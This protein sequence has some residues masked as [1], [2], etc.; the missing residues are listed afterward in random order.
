MPA[1]CPLCGAEVVKPEGEA[2]HR[3]PN[4]AC[5]SRGLET[6]IN[7]VGAAADIDGVGEQFVRRLWE[8][9]LAAL[10]AR[11]LPADDRAAA[12]ARGLRRGLGAERDRGDRAIANDDPV[13][14]RPLRPQH[15][16]R[17]LGDRPAARP[18]LRRRRPRCSPPARSSWSNARGSAPNAPRRSPSGSP[19]RTTAAW[20]RSSA[21]SGSASRRDEGD[22]PRQG[23]LSGKQ[24]VLTGTFEAFSREQAKAALE[25]L[26]REGLRQRLEEDG[27]GVRRARAPARRRRRPRR[28]GC[29]RSARRS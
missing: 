19:T 21:S 3:C 20:S 14:A 23:P 29:R 4:R 17:R 25:A 10:D 9:G 11:S 26:G 2:M 16:R 1:H 13:P 27:R 12:R 15:P 24:Y 22:R 18:P 5:P 8:E 28:R 6:L 7:W